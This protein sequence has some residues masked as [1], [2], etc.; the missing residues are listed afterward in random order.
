MKLS[1]IFLRSSF[2]ACL[3]L[4]VPSNLH[5]IPLAWNLHS[6]FSLQ[7]LRSSA[8]ICTFLPP[9]AASA[10]PV[11]ATTAA[12]G[13]LAVG[14]CRFPPVAPRPPLLAPPRPLPRMTAI[15]PISRPM[16]LRICSRS[17]AL[18]PALSSLLLTLC[19]AGALSSRTRWALAF[20]THSPW[21]ASRPQPS[22]LSSS[23]F[24]GF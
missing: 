13:A 19:I 7:I 3:Y 14:T 16:S 24:V 8:D 11:S 10:L 2:V 23:S 5:P 17:S 15:R 18:M 20:L 21:C 4:H 6:L 12:V 22:H 9:F 1:P